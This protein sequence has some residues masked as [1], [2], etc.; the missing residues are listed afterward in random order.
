[1]RPYHLLSLLLVAGSLAL[2]RPSST[3]QPAAPPSPYAA[4]KHGPPADPGYFPLAV[5]LQSPS[6]AARYRQAGINLYV[7]LWKGPTEEQLAALKAAGM[8]VICEQNA[9][10]LRHRDDPT[11]AG[12]MHGDE[13]DNAQPLP[14]GGYG[15]PIPAA[16]IIADYQRLKAAE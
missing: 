5:W 7:G 10:G 12:W 15:P 4:W 3:A 2:L 1:M 8:R 13:P 16:Q 6:M 14:G 11:I 9:V